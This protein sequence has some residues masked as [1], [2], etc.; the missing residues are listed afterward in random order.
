LH[1]ATTEDWK[2][3]VSEAAEVRGAAQELENSL[4]SHDFTRDDMKALAAGVIAVGVGGD[5]TDFPG[6]EQATMALGSIA[7]AMKMSGSLNGEQTKAMNNALAGLNK[8]VT[9]AG[10]YRPEA[11]LK[12]LQD[13]QKAMPQ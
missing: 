2:T 7:S 9:D 11:F 3:V 4:S 13:F 8:S 1:R 6:A 10:T 12:A 5:D